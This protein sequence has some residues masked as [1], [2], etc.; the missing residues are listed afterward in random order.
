MGALFGD[1]DAFQ[2]HHSGSANYLLHAHFNKRFTRF[3][4]FHDITGI[5]QASNNNGFYPVTPGYDEA[6]GIGTPN[7]AALITG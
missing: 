5:G 6:T 2:G 3:F 4:T 1:R 7:F